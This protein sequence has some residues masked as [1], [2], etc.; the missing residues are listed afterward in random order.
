MVIQSQPDMQLIATVGRTVEALIQY[1]KSLPDVVLMDRLIPG[2]RGVDALASIR[3][4]FPLARVIPLI[5]FHNYHQSAE[6]FGAE[7]S[8]CF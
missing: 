5:S 7:L 8:R 4:E 1:R 3:R 6:A 2:A